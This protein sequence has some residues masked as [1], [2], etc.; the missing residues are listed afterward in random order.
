[1]SYCTVTEVRAAAGFNEDTNITDP[2]IA[3]YISQMDSMIDALI[4][5]AY[6]LP[7]TDDCPF[8]SNQSIQ[9]TVALLYMNEFGEE[10]QNSNRDWNKRLKVVLDAC[11]KV[12]LLKMRLFNT[13][14]EELPRT[15]TRQPAFFPTVASSQPGA[16][17]STAPKIT[18]NQIY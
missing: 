1:M 16:V 17:N 13:A 10:N 15:T 3:S 14:G 18:M 5:S 7:I 11:D 12:R 9:G 4:G 6:L 2:T 8:L